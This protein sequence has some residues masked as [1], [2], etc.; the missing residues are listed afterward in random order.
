MFHQLASATN[1]DCEQTIYDIDPNTGDVLKKIDAMGDVT[2]FTWSTGLLLTSTDP[3]NNTTQF[4]YDQ[5]KPS[6]KIARDIA[7]WPTDNPPINRQR[8]KWRYH[9]CRLGKKSQHKQQ[10]RNVIMPSR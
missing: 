1:R 7:Q 9:R 10:N 6:P 4:R 8:Q 5:R 3:N 2:S